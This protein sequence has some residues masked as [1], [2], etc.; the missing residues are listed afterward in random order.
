M[1]DK[2][3]GAFDVVLCK[4]VSDVLWLT[5]CPM[6][7]HNPSVQYGYF[8]RNLESFHLNG[9]LININYQYKIIVMVQGCVVAWRRVRVSGCGIMGVCARQVVNKHH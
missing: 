2:G 7:L 1:L 5:R 4:G 3:T 6:L 9:K 8:G